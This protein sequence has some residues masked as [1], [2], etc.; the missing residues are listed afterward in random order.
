MEVGMATAVNNE[1]GQRMVTVEGQRFS[2]RDE[3]K[4][5]YAGAAHYWRLDRDKWGIIL[6]QVKKMGFTAISVYM[7]WEVHEIERGRFD[8]EGNKDID[9]FLTM[10][11]VKGFDIIARPGPQINSELTWFGYP[12]RILADPELHALN[13]EGTPAVLTQVPRPIPA[14]SY[15]ADK[16]FEE[17]G[18]WYDAICAILARHMYPA[19]RLL[20]V[21]VDNEMAYFFHINAYASDFHPAS[22]ALYRRFLAGKYDDIARLNLAYGTRHRG[23]EQVEP[24]RRFDARGRQ[25]IPYYLD[26]AAYRESYLVGAMDR[27][28]GMMRERGLTDIALFHNYPHPLGPGGSA[29]GF[30]A[31]FNMPAL[32]GKLDWVGFDVYSR[33]EL[34]HHVKTV[35]S[36]VVG[37]SRFPYIAE[38]IAGVWP[39][40]LDPGDLTDEEFVTKAVLMQGVKGFSRYMLVERD[41]WTDTPVRRDG[42]VRPDHAARPGWWPSRNWRATVCSESR[43][44]HLWCCPPSP[45]RRSASW[46]RGRSSTTSRPRN[47]SSTRR[48]NGLRPPGEK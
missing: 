47:N 40:Y 33:K 16:F 9:A 34:Y 32:E 11:E 39:W 31:P 15:A 8:F 4:T 19:G 35:L 30:T 5:F 42:R 18:L 14:V 22:V 13:A 24:P 45:S 46:T 2:V 25:D 21:Q 1:P 26:W 28:A 29:S 43:R 6:D 44:L 12:L 36:Y 17:A 48:G 38:L 27:L 37:T 41:R 20:A 23:F 3:T 7:P 10:L